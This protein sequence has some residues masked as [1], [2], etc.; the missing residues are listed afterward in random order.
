MTFQAVLARPLSRRVRR[1][2]IAG[3]GALVLL[4]TA[5]CGAASSTAPATGTPA[6]GAA[7]ATPASSGSHE[8]KGTLTVTG[9]VSQSLNFTQDLSVLPSCS[10]L[11][12]TGMAGQ[13]WSIPQPSSQA[14]SLNWNIT[15][16][17]GPGTFTDPSLFQDS[18]DLNVPYQGSD[19]QFDQVD[20]TTLS[21]T[22]SSDGSGSATFQ[23]LQDG[24]QLPENGT[25]T[26]TCS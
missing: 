6:Q 25:E 19:D 12:A 2:L 23:N 26:W 21:I 16:Y 18:V 10:D 11:A 24:D 1:H 13:T 4:C 20:G 14:F 9:T 3:A 17:S 22:V 5:A 7:T 8:F 15:P